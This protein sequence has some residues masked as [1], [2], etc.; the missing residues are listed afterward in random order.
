VKCID[1]EIPFEI[2][3]SWEWCRLGSVV[4]LI[5]GQ[6]FPPDKYNSNEDGIPYIIGA[7]NIFDGKLQIN[8]WTTTPSVFAG[9]GD[10]LLVCKGAGVG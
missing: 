10:L 4:S 8:R 7:S 3:E 2:P 5:S 9:K 1:E 6:D